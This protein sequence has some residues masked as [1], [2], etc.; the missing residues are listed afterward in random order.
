VS[1]NAGAPITFNDG[2][3]G[4][5]SCTLTCHGAAHDEKHLNY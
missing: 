2:G 3:L 5:G 4:H 1:S